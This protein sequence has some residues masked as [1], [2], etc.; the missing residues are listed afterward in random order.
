MIKLSDLL[1][2]KG[3]WNLVSTNFQN[4]LK[5]T[6]VKFALDQVKRQTYLQIKSKQF[7]VG[8][9]DVCNFKDFESQKAWFSLRRSIS[10]KQR[11]GDPTRLS[12]GGGGLWTGPCEG[13]QTHSGSAWRPLP[14]DQILQ[15][16]DPH[17]VQGF[18]NGEH[19]VISL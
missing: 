14:T 16:G 5:G 19:N 1:V 12:Y 7:G 3:F 18:Q 9:G 13:P 11:N 6:Q 8:L 2:N 10:R 4:T 17:H 15:A